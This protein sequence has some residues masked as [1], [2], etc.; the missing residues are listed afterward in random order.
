MIQEVLAFG[1][2]ITFQPAILSRKLVAKCN[3]HCQL[4]VVSNQVT[5]VGLSSNETTPISKVIV[6]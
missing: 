1:V 3:V 5:S 6:G 4:L 2:R